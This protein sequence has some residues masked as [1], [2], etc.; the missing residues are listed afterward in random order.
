MALAQATARAVQQDDILTRLGSAAATL[1]TVAGTTPGS[2]LTARLELAERMRAA[3]TAASER[4]AVVKTER[5]DASLSHRT[6]RQALDVV[7][8]RQRAARRSLASKNEAR[9]V[10]VTPG[11]QQ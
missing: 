7:V 4:A 2:A 6:A 3:S 1:D 8:E 11:A 9:A 10:P 5:D